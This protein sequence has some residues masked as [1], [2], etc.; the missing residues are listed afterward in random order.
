MKKASLVTAILA[1]SISAMAQKQNIQTASNYLKEKDYE[2][3]I[4]YI[5]MATNDP[6]TKDNAKAWYVKANIYMDMQQDPAKKEKKPYREAA[7]AYTKVTELDAKYERENVDNGLLLSAFNFYNDAVVEYNA[8]KYDDAYALAKSTVDIRNIDGGKRFAGRKQFD[9]IAAQ[10]QTIQ[11]FSAY[12]NKKYDEALPA[13]QALKSGPIPAGENIYLILSDIY[14][15]QNKDAEMLAVLEEAKAK[16]PE[17]QNVRNEELNYY[18]KSGKQ[19]ILIK[20]LED[21]VAKDPNNAEIL[22]NLANGYMGL[23][24]PKDAS[25]KEL[26]KPANFAEL[27]SKTEATYTT[28]LKIDP[29]NAGYNYNMGAF[30]YN[31]A[32]DLNKQMND[33]A[34]LMDKT[35]VAAEKKK[36]EEKYEALK[37]ERD[38]IFGKAMPYLDKTVQILDP[39]VGN[40][41]A[42]D[43]FSYQSALVAMREIYARQNNME[44]ASAL[45]KKLDESRTKK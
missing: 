45:K 29:N 22:F 10:A 14:K 12:Y 8:K 7:A 37:K 38:V 44:K 13:L 4:E 32:T 33:A 43:K 5:N 31:Q 18:I 28:A 25:G 27:I 11:A 9:T 20:K 39:K 40:M 6:S 2:K 34:D 17:S 3:A 15:V 41:S 21:A 42:D 36:Y 23:A 24:F 19:D 35:K 26:P 16:F 30:Y 1:I